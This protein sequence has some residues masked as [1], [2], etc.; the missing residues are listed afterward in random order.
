MGN[1]PY[2]EE[3]QYDCED[4]GVQVEYLKGVANDMLWWDVRSGRDY[5]MLENG[6]LRDM[7][8]LKELC[9]TGIFGGEV[10]VLKQWK[11]MKC[12]EEA[13][14][15]EGAGQRSGELEEARRLLDEDSCRLVGAFARR[16][17]ELQ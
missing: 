11:C 14:V 6:T 1:E 2:T 3:G 10:W 12:A 9:Q 15:T 16:S 5:E 13:E 4:F 17:R 8:C 7:G